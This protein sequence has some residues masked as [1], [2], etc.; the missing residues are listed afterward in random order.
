MNEINPPTPD[1]RL[2][3][4]DEPIMLGDIMDGP[5]GL[6]EVPESCVG[7]MASVSPAYPIFR[8]V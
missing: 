3:Q 2:V 5:D 7:K 6:E 1:L 4:F 8:K